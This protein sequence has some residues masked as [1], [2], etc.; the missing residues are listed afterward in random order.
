MTIDDLVEVLH[1]YQENNRGSDVVELAAD[2]EGN[3]FSELYEV[4]NSGPRRITLWPT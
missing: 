3:S 4:S 2:P 1:A